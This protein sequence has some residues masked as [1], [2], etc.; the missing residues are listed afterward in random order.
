MKIQ[1]FIILFGVLSC[2]SCTEE[3]G[4]TSEP[5]LSIQFN[6]RSAKPIFTKIRVVGAIKEISPQGI[7][8]ST[9]AAYGDLHLPL[10]LN[11]SQTTYIFEQQGRTDT[12][13]VFYTT[14]I[15]NF[16]RCGY[17]LEIAKP[18]TGRTI[19]SSFK[20]AEVQYNGYYAS[21]QSGTGGGINVQITEL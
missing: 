20:R 21:Y 5:T 8:P 14:N 7:K 16:R 18:T 12:L 17:V 10:N 2:L 9:E 6:W 3:C 13:T 19:L 1:V 11:E 15:Q 4:V